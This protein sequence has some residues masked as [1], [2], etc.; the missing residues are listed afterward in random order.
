MQFVTDGPDIPDE[1]LEAHEEGRVVF[2]CRAGISYPAGLPGF[3]GLV[4]NI[5]REAGTA[6]TPIE[7][8]AFDKGQFDATL[9]LLEHSQAS[10]SPHENIDFVRLRQLTAPL[11]RDCCICAV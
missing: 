1:L 6:R 10:L 7:Q 5:C 9:D 3:Q 4:E 11:Q 8:E 2:F